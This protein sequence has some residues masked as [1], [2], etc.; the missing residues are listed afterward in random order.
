MTTT[1]RWLQRAGSRSAEHSWALGS[2]LDEYCRIEA[3]TVDQ[4]AAFLG[5]SVDSLGWLALCRKPSREHFAEDI[6]KIAERFH[7]EGKKL[8]SIMRR[9]DIVA[10]LRR[11]VDVEDA[12]SLLLAARDRGEESTK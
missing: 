6:S 12:N 10:V 9:V 8:A 2:V 1:P 3:M 11:E 4:V 7:I 5:C